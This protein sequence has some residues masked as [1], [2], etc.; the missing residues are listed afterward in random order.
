MTKVAKS[1][2]RLRMEKGMTQEALASELFVTRQTVSGWENGRTQPDIE[3]LDLLAKIF[4]V[5]IE[6]LIYGKK[7]KTEKENKIAPY[8]ILSVVFAV[9]GSLLLSVG[10]AVVFVQGW[11]EFPDLFKKLL[12]FIPLLIGQG[13][14]VFA[15][16]KKRN[17][18]P[19]REGVSIAWC[20]GFAATLALA[21]SMFALRLSFE[22]CLL[23][24]ALMILPI[25]ILLDA[26]APIAAYYAAVIF[27]GYIEVTDTGNPLYFL[28]TFFLLLLGFA[29]CGYKN[30][31]KKA[32]D[33]RV[34]YS[35]WISVIA[36][37]VYVILMG[38]G[39]EIGFVALIAACFVAMYAFDTKESGLL[40]FR[41]LGLLG[42]SVTSVVISVLINPEW[43]DGFS[44]SNEPLAYTGVVLAAVILA[45]GLFL[46]RKTLKENKL[47]L[48]FCIS[49]S[50]CAVCSCV[51]D[52]LSLN[53]SVLLCVIATAAVFVQAGS[54]IAQ[55]ATENRFAPLNLGMLMIFSTVISI[56][57]A[58]EFE[59]IGYGLLCS[60]LGALLLLINFILSRKM[61]RLKA[62]KE[63][64][65]N[66]E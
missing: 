38:F 44:Y 62:E 47:K 51:G 66:E 56:A 21:E 58:F 14:G 60:A 35:L 65:N 34:V 32:K 49:A 59:V 43:Y 46:G 27:Y 37:F 25:F 53:D 57:V 9:L 13:L 7:R 63:G 61:R 10:V 31:K 50:V 4:S 8:K 15:V 33:L 26:V 30:H 45:G 1:I 40:P 6:E 42:S 23:A 64:D 18:I 17:S 2:K 55:G 29:Y 24:D 39:V 19:W 36:A 54:L 48:I 41:H 3:T 20:L 28:L 22:E 16:V 12:S 11:Q 52:I 5:E